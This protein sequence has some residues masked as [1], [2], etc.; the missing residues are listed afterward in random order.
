MTTVKKGDEVKVHYT[1]KLPNGEIFDSSEGREPL[2]FTVGAGMMIAGFDAG[3]V[4]MSNGDKKTINVT[5]AEGYGERS[6][7]QIFEFPAENIPP[8]MKLEAGMKLD[9]RNEQGM[10][11]PVTVLEVRPDSVILDANH[12]LAGKDLIFEVEMV[13]INGQGKSLIIMP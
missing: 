11:I 5:S 8:D 9:L 13:E 1:G 10:P 6:E 4:G 7:E 12:F 2:A 3:V